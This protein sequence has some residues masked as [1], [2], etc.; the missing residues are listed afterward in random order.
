MAVRT[1]SSVTKTLAVLDYVASS[2]RPVR[3]TEVAKAL[4]EA[5]AA[6]HQRLITLADGGWIEQTEEGAYRLTLRIVRYASMAMEQGN[7][8]E[9]VADVLQDMVTDSLETA[10]LAVLEGHEAVILRRVESNGILRADLRVGARLSL[11]L[12]AMGRI[13]M[14]HARPEL[15]AQLQA[16]G[17]KLPSEDELALYRRQGYAVS[18]VSGPRAVSA[19]AVPVFDSHDQ[20]IATLAI[21]GPQAGF[22]LDKCAA[23]ASAAADVVNARLR[24]AQA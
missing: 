9:R 15:I 19:V 21:S 16:E 6:T 2:P 1:L 7:L 3:L 12:S 20:C 24:G 11:E 8:G 18:G 13:L 23:I 14:A 17:V 5:R 10:S 4:E 22:D